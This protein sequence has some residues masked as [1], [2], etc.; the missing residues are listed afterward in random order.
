MTDRKHKHRRNH[1]GQ[2]NE[3][4]QEKCIPPQPDS[5]R[6]HQHDNIPSCAAAE[7]SNRGR[8]ERSRCK[9]SD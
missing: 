4:V 5:N 8:R 1:R 7:R 6:H 2:S 3:T 9:L